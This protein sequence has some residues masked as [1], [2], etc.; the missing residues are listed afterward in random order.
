MTQAVAA[1][2]QGPVEHRLLG[3]AVVVLDRV[4]I[5]LTSAWREFAAWSIR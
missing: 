3:E 4:M 5:V 1:T 2:S